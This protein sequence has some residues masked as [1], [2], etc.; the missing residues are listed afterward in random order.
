MVI[1]WILDQHVDRVR[2]A[3]TPFI[4]AARNRHHRVYGLRDSLIPKP[5]ELTG[6]TTSDSTIVRGSHGFVNYVQHELNPSPGG[7]THPTNFQP[8]TYTPILKDHC[9]NEDFQMIE[10]GNFGKIGKRPALFIKPLE[11]MKRFSGVI[12]RGDQSIEE[13]HI[14]KYGKWLRPNDSCKMMVSEAKEIYSEYR[15]VVID[16]KAITGSTY[17]AKSEIPNQVLEF[18]DQIDE[19]WRPA[20]VYVVDVVT[21][22]TGIK[23]LEYNQ[24]GTS[25]M[26]ACNQERI[27]DA[28]IEMLQLRQ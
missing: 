21:T 9:L 6:I 28:L 7:F 19:S 4:E 25:A 1:T 10:Y 22:P 15:V 8:S 26:Y 27:I 13:A 5:I 11:E 2:N 20:E 3:P 16:G 18:V 17:D 23:I 14:E 24:F 12:V